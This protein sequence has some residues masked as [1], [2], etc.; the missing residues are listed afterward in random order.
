MSFLGSLE[1]VVRVWGLWMVS[2]CDYS[3]FALLFRWDLSGGKG[4]GW[5]LVRRGEFWVAFEEVDDICYIHTF[6]Q[7]SRLRL[8]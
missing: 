4:R 6:S 7:D 5:W 2:I 1:G 8:K 3:R